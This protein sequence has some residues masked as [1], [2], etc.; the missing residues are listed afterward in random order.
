MK[1]KRVVSL[2]MAVILMITLLPVTPVNAKVKLNTT[3]R[4]LEVGKTAIISISGAK[5]VKWSVNNNHIRI[6]NKSN[7]YAKIKGISK[8][9][10]FLKAKVGKKMY[11]CK[12]TVKLSTTSANNDKVNF[13]SQKAKQSIDTEEIIANKKL[14]VKVESDYKYATDVS[15]KCTFYNSS[16]KPVDY[17][18]DS[19]SFLE[20]GHTGFLEFSLPDV[21]Y[22]YYDIVYEY[23]EGLKY[24]YHLS[25]IKNLSLSTNYVEDE[26]NPYIM[27]QVSNSGKEECYRCEVAIVF[28]DEYGEILDVSLEPVGKISS[29][30]SE[31][32]KAYMPYDRDT[33][34]DIKYSNYEA[35]ITYA[36]H[37]GKAGETH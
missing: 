35:F 3:S 23:S 18:D 14:F 11:K 2:L 6:V 37:L 8:G 15:A 7:S 28:Y 27:L 36:Y 30:S 25:V 20:K 32:K 16:G 10:S 1:N 17:S 12:I 21:E 19:I 22:S 24:L 13:N 31:T 26:Y 9:I 4:E 33:Y 5:S 29:G 34:E